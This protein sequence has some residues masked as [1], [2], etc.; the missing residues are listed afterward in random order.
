M[1][2]TGIDHVAI[3][4]RSIEEASGNY[5]TL[6]GVDPD[7]ETVEEQG[8]RIAVF[9]LGESRLELI[10][11]LDSEN[12]IA[13]FLDDSGEGIHHVALKTDSIDE[14]LERLASTNEIT[15]LDSE[16]REG[17]EGYRIAFLHPKDLNGA[18][19]ELAEPATVD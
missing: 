19:I 1:N 3:A 7:Y 12:A 13:R 10:E 11:P 9:D 4:V 8:V 16:S 15:C 18:L 14:D 17:A 5:E 6:L 2:F